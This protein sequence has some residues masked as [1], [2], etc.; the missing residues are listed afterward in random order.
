MGVAVTI[1][2]ASTADKTLLSSDVGKTARGC[3][4]RRPKGAINLPL[5]PRPTLFES[6]QIKVYQSLKHSS[7]L[8]KPTCKNQARRIWKFEVCLS[9]F[10]LKLTFK[11]VTQ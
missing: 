3:E 10:K 5:Y 2:V 1:V 11:F 4:S 6:L 8:R 9:F 7:V